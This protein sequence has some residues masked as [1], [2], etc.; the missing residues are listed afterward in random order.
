MNEPEILALF[1]GISHKI[2]DFAIVEIST[3]RLCV[4]KVEYYAQI[5]QYSRGTF[6]KLTFYD[7]F[8]TGCWFIY[9]FYAI[10]CLKRSKVGDLSF[11]KEPNE[12]LFMFIAAIHQNGKRARCMWFG[13]ILTQPI[14]Y[15]IIFIKWSISTFDG[16]LYTHLYSYMW[17]YIL[18]YV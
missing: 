3:F 12:K 17:M 5:W 16:S 15:F 2:N 4:F 10:F 7:G 13:I 9:A 6:I 8:F 11:L 18:S 14:N 1:L